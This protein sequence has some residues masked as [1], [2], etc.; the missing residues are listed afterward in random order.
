VR[1]T[2]TTVPGAYVIDLEKREDERGFFARFFCE[3]EFGDQGLETRFVQ[4]NN[5][6]SRDQG[7]LRGLHYQLQPAAE[8][9]VLRVLDG[10]VWDVVLDLREGSPTFGRWYGDELTADNRRMMY[11]PR[12]FAHG[13]VTLV[14][15]TE[16]LYL[17]SAAFSPELER[18]V[19]WND[20]RFAIEWPVEPT[21]IS[22]KDRSH[23]DF[24]PT[25]HL[26]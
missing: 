10:A 22:E 23:P 21:V 13:F 19:R 12:G 1:F 3:R 26:A 20:P 17:V 5:S 15:D 25:T 16:V 6:L 9:K 14:P 24:D 8:V 18:G 7:T 11:V 4:I 2:E